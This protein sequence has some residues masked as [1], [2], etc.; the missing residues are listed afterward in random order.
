MGIV[1]I[2]PPTW[3]VSLPYLSVP[4]LSA[5]MKER[6]IDVRSIDANLSSFYYLME[7]ASLDAV[8]GY[9]HSAI[10]KPAD[11]KHRV[12]LK[13]AL[14]TC[15]YII[16]NKDKALDY[17][18]KTQNL[19]NYQGLLWARQVLEE[20]MDLYSARYYPMYFTL[21]GI[22]DMIKN[23]NPPDIMNFAEDPC[24]PLKEY[25][26][27][28]LIPD[29]MQDS[30]SIVGFS[31]ICRDQMIHSV[32]LARM[33][34]RD[35]PGVHTCL[36]GCFVNVISDKIQKDFY[37]LE[38]YFDSIIFGQGEIPLYNLACMVEG[39]KSQLDSP[40][41]IILLKSKDNPVKTCNLSGYYRNYPVPDFSDFPLDL[42]ISCD[43]MLPYQM[44]SG[45]YYGK[46]AFCNSK[47]ATTPD[48]VVKEASKIYQDLKEL[49]DR[50][51]CSIFHINDEALNLNLVSGIA[52]E[53]SRLNLTI[54]TEARFEK[55]LDLEKL[56]KLKKA[57]VKKVAF[58]FE[59]GNK[60]VLELM[61]KGY[62][63]DD[64]REILENC[65]DIGIDVHLFGII[66]FPGETEEE[67]HDTLRF[68]KDLTSYK[69]SVMFGYFFHTFLLEYNSKVYRNP[70]KYGIA[71]IIESDKFNFYADY[72]IKG[73]D[74]VI[75]G[76]TYDEIRDEF[77]RDLF[78]NKP[79]SCRLPFFSDLVY[80]HNFSIMEYEKIL[81]EKD[82]PVSRRF[83]LKKS[84]SAD[85]ESYF[86]IYDLQSR[87]LFS[88]DSLMFDIFSAFADQNGETD[89]P[90][91]SG[92][93]GIPRAL[94]RSR[95]NEFGFNRII[96]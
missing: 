82:I 93:L 36:G 14:S 47:S 64:A 45:C 96:K 38:Q 41:N 50:Y 23:F 31:A 33:L 46:C 80:M 40:E 92:K 60:R 37:P 85:K 51:K 63:L 90:G 59:S 42:Y 69:K 78:S 49:K 66:A 3:D 61:E 7:T 18:R 19:D 30:P 73:D 79:N 89:I 26:E 44:A 55:H 58:G 10:A 25:Y 67:R 28:K 1:L 94:V 71:E 2:F 20:A 88:V 12:F 75:T 4:C 72:R 86:Y 84:E 83:I 5:Y 34:K 29:I 68:V 62:D 95:I 21:Y 9:I 35:F 77:H 76:R 8:K 54:F 87:N 53:L 24:Y 39:K 57:G 32:Y 70:E 91:I 43:K 52:D 56:K 13:R 27:K 22:V 15:D 16:E 48:Y 11:D 74:N 6:G 17:F 65:Y 81:E